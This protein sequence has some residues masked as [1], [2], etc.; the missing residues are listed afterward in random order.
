M[1]DVG[2]DLLKTGISPRL[3]CGRGGL[4]LNE[5]MAL[6]WGEICSPADAI[7]D[8]CLLSCEPLGTKK[9][10]EGHLIPCHPNLVG[11]DMKMWCLYLSG[12]HTYATYFSCLGRITFEGN[13][14]TAL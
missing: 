3:R 14:V 12:H 6:V 11:A 1:Q 13:R 7:L 8:E 10:S 9:G 4:G 2:H 5:H